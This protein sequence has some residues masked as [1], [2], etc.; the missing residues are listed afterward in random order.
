MYQDVDIN[1]RHAMFGASQDLTTACGSALDGCR[2]LDALPIS[3]TGMLVLL[4][5]G[6]GLRDT[7]G[8]FEYH[9]YSL[10]TYAIT[11]ET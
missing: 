10:P 9:A 2:A 5:I 3:D 7:P 6:V 4:L 11:L 8:T 1:Q